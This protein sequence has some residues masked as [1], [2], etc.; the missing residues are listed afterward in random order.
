MGGYRHIT[1][2]K[3]VWLTPEIGSSLGFP[4]RADLYTVLAELHDDNGKTIQQKKVELH[5]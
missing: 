3:G 1:N 5:Q 2:A 4:G